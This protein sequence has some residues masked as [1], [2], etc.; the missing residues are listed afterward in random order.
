[1]SMTT[2]VRSL[3]LSSVGTS[4]LGS[5]RSVRA[6]A[7]SAWAS[8][9]QGAH[10]TRVGSPGQGRLELFEPLLCVGD[11]R[12]GGLS[13]VVLDQGGLVARGQVVD[14]RLDVIGVE[15]GVRPRG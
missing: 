1:M 13:P 5:A 10:H 14:R 6:L 2:V 4:S 3:G 12:P 9:I 15:D 8:L 7:R 11:A